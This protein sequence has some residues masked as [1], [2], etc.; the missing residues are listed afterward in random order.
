MSLA[1][2][3]ILIHKLLNKDTDIVPE[4]EPL[5]ILN[6]KSSVCMANNGTYTN[7]TRK[8]ARVLHFSINVENI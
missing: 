2:F 4:A 7:Y 8:I 6:K 5:I 3:R 1:H